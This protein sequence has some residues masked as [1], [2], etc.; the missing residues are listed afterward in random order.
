M[1]INSL[2]K[3]SPERYE[4]ALT[5]VRIVVGITFLAH[6]WQKLFVNGI[7]GVTGFF[8][9]LGIPASGF[10]AI[11]VT[12]LELIG[13]FALILGLGTRIVS[14]L[15]AVDMLV[16]LVLVHLPNGFFVSNGGVELV[17]LL[18]VASVSLALSGAGA[19]SVDARIAPA[20]PNP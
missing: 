19:Y 5:L 15:L 14:A 16:A 12:L 2:L 4:L 3:A 1:N 20:D 18:L 6:G 10:F 8:G 13:G 17:L 11:V 9:S 7:P